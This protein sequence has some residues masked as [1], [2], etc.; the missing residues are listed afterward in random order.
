M[1]PAFWGSSEGTQIPF[2]PTAP[3]KKCSASE[4]GVSLM[5]D[6]ERK[7]DLLGS[8]IHTTASTHWARICKSVFWLGLAVGAVSILT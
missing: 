3:R 4:L 2:L 6:K 7:D 5:S 8:L 1:A